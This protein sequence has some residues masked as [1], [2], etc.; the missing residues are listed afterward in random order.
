MSDNKQTFSC[1]NESIKDPV[2]LSF[3]G[4]EFHT[5]YSRIT[6]FLSCPR[7]YRYTYVDGI[8]GE[9][10]GAMKRGSAYHKTLEVALTFKRD[11]GR[12][13]S[14][15]KCVELARYFAEQY[16]LTPAV[17]DQ[18][19]SA[20][21]YWHAT[22]YHTLDPLFIEGRFEIERNGVRLT[23]LIDLG[24][25]TGIVTDHKFS[26]ET[27]ST[28]R[29]K[30]SVQP[31]IYQWGWEDD[32]AKKYGVPYKRFEYHAI[33]TFPGVQVQRLKVYPLK[34]EASLWYE[35]QIRDVA[36]AMCS[37]IFFA[38]PSVS[39]C[40][41]CEHRKRCKPATYTVRSQILGQASEEEG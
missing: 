19:D 25:T 1:G 9:G 35:K 18:V 15:G 29:A 10:N 40:G 30:K 13:L 24:D 23:G 28:D 7:S 21:R 17:V 36:E 34:E 16:E 3:R 12:E 4:K 14:V 41:R 20:V 33:K 27:W 5:G 8:R 26:F 22:L 31:I 6:K 39:E 37:G 2:T 32:F 38:T 11:K